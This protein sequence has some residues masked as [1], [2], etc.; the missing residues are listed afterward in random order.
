MSVP[1][2]LADSTTPSSQ[3]VD[4]CR[5]LNALKACPEIFEMIADCS[6]T[7]LK[8]QKRLREQFSPDLVR[9][10]LALHDA[11]QKAQ[12][13][14]PQASQLWL[15]RVGLEQS[16]AWPVAQ[17]KAR[18]FEKVDHVFDL[19]CG[20]GIDSASL[21]ACT[22]VTAVDIDSAMLLRCLW[23]SHVFGVKTA[24]STQ[25][26]DV[27]TCDWTGKFVH[28]DPDRR[29]GRDRPVKRLEQYSPPLEWMQQLTQ[30]AAGG[31][32]KIS[33]ASNFIQKFPGCEIELISMDGECREATVWFG[34]LAGAH[35][36]RATV[37]PGGETISIDPLSAWAPQATE[38]DAYI[39]DPDPS[40]VRAGM[41][42][43]IAEL[44]GMQRLD[45]QEEYLT[46]PAPLQ[47]S[48]V[49]AFQVQAVLPNNL[50]ELK[51]WLRKSPSSQYEIKCRHIPT[52][53]AAM[54]KQLPTG[55][56]PPRTIFVARVAGKAKLIVTSRMTT[57]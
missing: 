31:A 9:A 34:E 47:T 22:K 37:L 48:F 6:V 33:P 36:F 11:R 42:D 26:A 13:F 44:H 25:V 45:T 16:T 27:S 7:E 2:P 56:H 50:R 17:Y 8:N 23:N 53:A 40:V 41:L 39:F 32:I 35:S 1:E 46:G 28:A 51:R 43:G 52:D 14:L 30:S 19:C 21:A 38:C 15:T 57:S 12:T 10:A 3:M 4:E 20:I 54:Q 49:T 24:V 29:A 5:I 18:R 55:D